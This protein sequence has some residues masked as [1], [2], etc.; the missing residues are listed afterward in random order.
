MGKKVRRIRP[1]SL[2]VGANNNIKIV[3]AQDGYVLLEVVCTLA[4]IALLAAIILPTISRRTSHQRLEAFAYQTAA[5]LNADR[6]AAI[7]RRIEIRTEVDAA[8]RL[9]KSGSGDLSL[10]LP[11]DVAIDTIL[12]SR[13]GARAAG[14]AIV[15][16]PSGLS[17]GGVVALTQSHTIY[18]IRV[19]WITG[20]VEV[21][22]VNPS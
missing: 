11:M 21:V 9:I 15:F 12:A 19:N 4:I 18:Q 2:R 8:A 3:A 16:F 17:C 22:P 13:C 6:S 10:R 7:R 14:T 1:I 5:I 20:G